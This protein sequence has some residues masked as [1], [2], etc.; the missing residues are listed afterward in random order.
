[1]ALICSIN[2]FDVSQVFDDQTQR[3]VVGEV[4]YWEYSPCNYYM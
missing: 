2:T 4:M 1:M 3:A